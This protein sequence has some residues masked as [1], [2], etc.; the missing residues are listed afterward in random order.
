MGWVAAAAGTA[1]RLVGRSLPGVAGPLLVAGGLWM[2]YRPLGV[3]F[4]GAVL[5]A[6]DRRV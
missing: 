4:A 3:I 2:V 1:V 6:L 5:W